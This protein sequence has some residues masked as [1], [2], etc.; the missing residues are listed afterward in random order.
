MKEREGER[1]REIIIIT[2]YFPLTGTCKIIHINNTLQHKS[3][4]AISHDIMSTGK[5]VICLW[6]GTNI[7]VSTRS[8]IGL[9]FAIVLGIF[10]NAIFYSYRSKQ[11]KPV[12]LLLSIIINSKWS[13]CVAV[14][15]LSCMT[16]LTQI[17]HSDCVKRWT[18]HL[19]STGSANTRW[20]KKQQLLC[21]ASR[22][23]QTWLQSHFFKALAAKEL[24][25][26]CCTKLSIRK[27]LY[28]QFR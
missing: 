17:A 18:K 25:L 4:R 19:V 14:R 10:K 15:F 2:G 28:S 20:P 5:G 7:Q 21:S 13:T 9:L 22:N 6:E 11:N 27:R 23:C 3:I 26:I 1:V 12:W 8:F 16:L 24:Q